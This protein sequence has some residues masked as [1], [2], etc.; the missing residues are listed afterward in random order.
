MSVREYGLQFDYAPTIMSKMEDHI[1]RFVMGLEQHLL[2]NR[3]SISLPAYMDISRIQAYAQ[4]VEEFMQKQRATR[5]HDRDKNKRAI[6]SGPSG[7]GQ[8][9]RASGSQYRGESSQMRPP[10]PR[11]AQY[12]KQHAGQCRMGLGV[13]YTCGYPGHVTRDCPIRGDASIAQP[14]GSVAGLSSLV[15]PLGQGSQ[16]PMSRGSGRGEASSSSGPQNRIYALAG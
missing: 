10:L 1:H 11:C 15:R 12:G 2:N 6:S 7:P 9:F 16:V 13:C 5:E 3:M 4:G 8:N 14:V